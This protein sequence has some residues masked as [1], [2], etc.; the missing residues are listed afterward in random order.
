[1]L[2]D[3]FTTVAQ[4]F[5]FLILLWLLKR[6]LYKPILNAMNEREEK[7]TYRLREAKRAQQEAEQKALEYRQKTEELESRRENLLMDAT[8]EVEHLRKEMLNKAR[9]EVH[10]SQERWFR[11]IQQSK[12]AFLRD[13]YQRVSNQTYDV[14][15]KALWD[16]ANEDLESHIIETFLGRLDDL[17]GDEHGSLERALAESNGTITVRSAFEIPSDLRIAIQDRIESMTPNSFEMSY[18]SS[19]DLIS[20]IELKLAGKKISWCLSSYLEDLEENLTHALR[21]RVQELNQLESKD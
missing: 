9:R 5:N 20:G 19:P 6:F 21:E 8:N 4:I 13:L 15:R 1:M 7:I 14:A 16:L 11:S 17:E 10:E 3:W 12:E 2:F 18:E